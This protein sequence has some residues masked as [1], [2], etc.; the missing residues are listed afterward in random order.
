MTLTGNLRYAGAILRGFSEGA[1][2]AGCALVPT[3]IWTIATAAIILFD[4][5]YMYDGATIVSARLVSKPGAWKATLAVCA[6]WVLWRP[7]RGA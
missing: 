7:K 4:A 5:G 3:S 1:A 6:I 2:V